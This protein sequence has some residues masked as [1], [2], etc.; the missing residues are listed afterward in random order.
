M[1]FRA[2]IPSYRGR[3]FLGIH[4]ATASFKQ[5]PQYFDIIGGKFT[6]H[7]SAR[8]KITVTRKNNDIFPDM[9]PFTVRD[10]LYYHEMKQPVEVHFTAEKDGEEI[11]L[12]WTRSHGNGRAA[13]VMFG[14][15]SIV[16]K[17]PE[18]KKIICSALLWSLKRQSVGI[19]V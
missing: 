10:E 19:V 15:R 2:L 16:L 11:P 6:G 3:G 9:Q 12:V 4:S 7:G 13:Y 1:P 17:N 5:I 18:V 14:H 8:E